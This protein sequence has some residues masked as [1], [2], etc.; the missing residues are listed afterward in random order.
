MHQT[1]LTHSCYRWMH[2]YSISMLLSQINEQGE[3]HPVLHFNKK[4]SDIERRY[5]TTEKECVT[6][7]LAVKITSLSS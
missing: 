6:I 2:Y 1:T 3:E 7:V 5:N 4:L